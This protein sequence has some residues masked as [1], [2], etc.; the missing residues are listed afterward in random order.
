MPRRPSV[1]GPLPSLAIGVLGFIGFIVAVIVIVLA[2]ILLGLLFGVL[3]LPSLVALEGLAG[4]L[5]L[6]G[7]ILVFVVA[8]A[9]LAD[10]VVGLSLA[11][12][13]SPLPATFWGRLGL[14]AAGAAV[15]VILTSLPI[16]GGWLKLLVILLGL[17]AM[18][19]V[20]WRWWQGRATAARSV[21]P[22]QVPEAAAA[23]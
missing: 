1:P 13:V 4:A 17:G 22:S 10:A 18:L 20:A 14:L 15:V 12:L 9:F 19:L 11:T 7:T 21:A 2:I 8:T 5:A 3:T 23:G 6:F 16:I